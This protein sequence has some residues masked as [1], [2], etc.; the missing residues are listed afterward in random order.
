[1]LE[2]LK[3]RKTVEGDAI[4]A[5]EAKFNEASK[6]TASQSGEGWEG[7]ACVVRHRVLIQHRRGRVM[8]RR[9]QLL[10]RACFLQERTTFTRGTHNTREG[11]CG[12]AS[13]L[14]GAGGCRS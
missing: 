2:E 12:K 14:C 6:R 8:S 5:Q 9:L 10:H 7:E 11:C 13:H 3:R 1:M 4:K